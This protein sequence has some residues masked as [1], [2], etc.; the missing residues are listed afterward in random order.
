VRER[1]VGVWTLLRYESR[2]NGG[3]FLPA[4][5]EGVSG[6]LMYDAQGTMAGQVMGAGRALFRNADFRKGADEEKQAAFES[7]IAYYG[8]YEVLE[9]ERTVLHHVEGSLFPNWVGTTQ[10]RLFEFDGG[11]L[12]LRQVSADRRSESRLV[13]VRAPNA[14]DA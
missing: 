4:M 10:R 12:V 14:S 3:E 11:M 2:V 1:F 8:T 7:Y 9:A 6:R 5:G 13:W